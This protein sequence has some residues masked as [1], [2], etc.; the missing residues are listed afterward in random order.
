M[1]LVESSPRQAPGFSGWARAGRRVPLA[2]RNLLATWRRHARSL[3]G[4]AFA[5]LLMMVEVGL[6]TG[7]VES[8][9]ATMRRLNGEIMVISTAKYQ[10]D[11]PA[12]FP[13]RQ[14]Y[15]AR[16]VAGVASARP[17]YVQRGL[18]KNPQDQ[19]L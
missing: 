10:F 1:T 15:E 3:A 17:L 14:L 4:I 5:A 16:G 18:W 7:F 2:R 19:K 9:L 12:P 6:D 11:S 8:S 13:R